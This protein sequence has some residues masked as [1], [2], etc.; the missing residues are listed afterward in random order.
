MSHLFLSG[1]G[2]GNQATQLYR[3]F[4]AT[5]P[6]GGWILY[7]PIAMPESKRTF[8]NCF[9][10]IRQELAPFGITKID[11]WTDLTDRKL[12]DLKSYAAVFI[13][14]GN[15]FSLLNDLRKSGFD[16]L[17]KKFYMRGGVIAGSS[18]GAVI[19]GKPMI[20]KLQ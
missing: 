3:E 17:L 9:D 8:G 5:I 13:G 15:S 18:A 2:K 14:G 16:M 10:W 19:L 11:M 12:A 4:S 1:G 6:K 7:V 20:L